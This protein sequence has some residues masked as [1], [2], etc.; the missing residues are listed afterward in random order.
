M[1]HEISNLI[2]P[3]I[4]LNL[5][6]SF[7]KHDNFKLMQ[8]IKAHV[9]ANYNL[10]LED[11]INLANSKK[12]ND[13]SF[14]LFC[15]FFRKFQIKIQLQETNFLRFEQKIQVLRYSETCGFSGSEEIYNYFITNLYEG[16]KIK[17]IL[18]V[19]FE[20]LFN[21]LK[22]NERKRLQNYIV[23]KK[24]KKLYFFS[25]KNLNII[26]VYFFGKEECEILDFERERFTDLIME[27]M[28]L[29]SW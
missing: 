11:K 21:S 17:R 1:N 5:I 26:C 29:N 3:F 12:I 27:Q 19:N 16:K 2:A 4:D 22:E 9:F 28:N 18:N 14:I 23:E 8:L 20:N 10:T 13:F 25:L 6:Y 24:D 15:R 7:S